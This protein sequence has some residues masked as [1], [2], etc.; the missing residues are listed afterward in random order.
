MKIPRKSTFFNLTFS[1]QKVERSGVIN[2]KSSMS[3][4]F[5]GQSDVSSISAAKVITNILLH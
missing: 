4:D 3:H 1:K 2:S 5:W